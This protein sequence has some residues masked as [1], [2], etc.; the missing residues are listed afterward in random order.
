MEESKEPSWPQVRLPSD[1]GPAG[2]RLHS[3]ANPT[4][5]LYAELPQAKAFPSQTIVAHLGAH[6]TQQHP[7]S[8][9]PAALDEEGLGN[10]E[11]RAAPEEPGRAGLR[12]RLAEKVRSQRAHARPLR[13]PEHSGAG[14]C[15]RGGRGGSD[16]G[17]KASSPGPPRARLRSALGT[18]RSARGS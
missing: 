18:M 2:L 10:L 17:G 12:R 3:S 1:K 6:E 4:Y 13:R 15:R 8:R 11:Q 7:R 14:P 16:A 9:R 5:L